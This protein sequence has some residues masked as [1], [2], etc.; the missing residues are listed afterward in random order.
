MAG[1]DKLNIYQGQ[2]SAYALAERVYVP[3]EGVNLETATSI[4]TLLLRDLSRG[5]TYDHEGRKIPMTER[6]FMRRLF[7]LYP[8]ALKHYGKEEAQ[9][10]RDMLLAVFA[11]RKIPSIYAK[12]VNLEGENKDKI[13]RELMTKRILPMVVPPNVRGNKAK[14]SVW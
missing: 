6:L 13:I 9:K 7:Y 10:V 14:A 3:G 1:R 4:A 2:R 5:W 8:L 12:F 11:S